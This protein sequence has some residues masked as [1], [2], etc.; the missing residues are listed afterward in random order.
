MESKIS[1]RNFL[2]QCTLVGGACCTFM[3]WNPKLSAQTSNEENKEKEKKPVDLKQ[4]SIC[5]IPCFQS[6]PLYKATIENNVEAKKVVY[7]Q[8]EMKKNFGFEFDPEK[9]FCYG[10]KAWD[11]PENKLGLSTC[12]GRKCA[13][14]NE[15]EA[16]IQCKNL[17]SCDKEIWKKWPQL[18]EHTK[19]MQESYKTQP[20][21]VMLDLKSKT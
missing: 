6:C 1:R 13:K 21:A 17:S 20:G 8:W 16:C 12:D 5:G 3:M 19:K 10:C 14:A 15:M 11:K 4:L 18:Y 2:K 7:E 9:V